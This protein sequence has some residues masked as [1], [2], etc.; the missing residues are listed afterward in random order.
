MDELSLLDMDPVLFSWIRSFLTDKTQAVH[1][2]DILLDWRHTIG[3]I[4]QGIKMGVTLFAI[5]IN[6]FLRVW[7]VRAK[8]V[9]DTTVVEILPHNL[10][11]LLDLAVTDTHSFS[12]DHKMKLNPH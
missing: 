10:I 1:I 9:D 12:I 5:M 7:N 8:Y 6:R 3:G 4:P 2:R 11:S